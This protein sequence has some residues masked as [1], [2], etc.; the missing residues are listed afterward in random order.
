[1]FT[2]TSLSKKAPEF[3]VSEF[4][5]FLE[6]VTNLV[7][8]STTPPPH[9]YP[10]TPANIFKSSTDAWTVICTLESVVTRLN[11]LV[12][13]PQ[14]TVF[15]LESQKLT[16]LKGKQQLESIYTSDYFAR[17]MHAHFMKGHSIDNAL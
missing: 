17:E 13:P 2:I 1:M 3:P 5:E 12:A 6:H 11:N 9:L 8:Y 4:L 16:F 15:F 14:H 10:P 7:V